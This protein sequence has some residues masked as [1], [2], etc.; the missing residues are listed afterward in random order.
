MRKIW[1]PLALVLLLAAVF[2]GEGGHAEP[3]VPVA[4]PA[5]DT[6]AVYGN[7]PEALRP[8]GSFVHPYKQFFVDPL[9]FTGPGR[10]KPEPE[11]ETV[12]LG[13]LAPLSRS[14]E[15]YIGNPLLW[16]TQLAID[17][18]NAAGGYHGKPYEL[19]VRNDTGLWG[20]SANEMVAFSYEDSVWA[21]IGTVDGANTHIA[22]RVALKTELVVM[23][24][25]DTD[26]TLVET[27]IPWVFRNIADDRQ[28]AYTLAYY[29]YDERNFDRVAI[30][31]ANNRYGRFGVGE[32]RAG[33]VR[34]RR[35]APIEINYELAYNHVNPDFTVQIERLKRVAPDA[36]VLWADAEAA[37]HLLN[38]MRSAGLTMPV[39]ACDRVVHPKFLE[40]AGAA[41]EGVVVAYP[42]N[43]DADIPELKLFQQNYRQRFQAEPT[44][45][46]AHAYDGTWMTIRAIEQAGLNRYRIRDALA[47]MNVYH[48]VTG[49]IVFDA[50]YSDRGPVTMATVHGGRFVF[51]DPEVKIR[52]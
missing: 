13:I 15:A 4:V 38:R 50:A 2:G 51:N 22:I 19:I 12:K 26:P 8:F 34:L 9:V 14:H 41:A 25:G 16:G 27:K 52:F 5:A 33:S 47:A 1:S 28:M 43:P 10:D 20:A 45:Y 24:V 3:E 32:F 35:P 29:L 37:G 30:L 31:R 44:V 17:E 6:I 49:E 18:A 11:V 40:I 46:A 42:Y 23:N 36:V 39:F 7:T 21:V 48:G